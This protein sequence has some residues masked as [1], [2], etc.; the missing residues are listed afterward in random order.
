MFYF[1]LLF[2]TV[3][4]VAPTNLGLIQRIQNR[5]IR[6]IYKL[7]WDSP[8]N[9]LF[10]TSGVIFIRERFLQ[11]SARH[12]AKAIKRANAFICPLISEYI[13]S[14]SAITAR[15]HEM[16]TLLCYSTAL[17][18]ITYACIVFMKMSVLCFIVFFK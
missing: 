8:T 10:P 7:K 11:L 13:R 9:E 14:W 12:L 18:A 2:F 3:A 16:S 1:R 4:C 15:G 17:I 6:C 5:A